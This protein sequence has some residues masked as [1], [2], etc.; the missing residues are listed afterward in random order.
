MPKAAYTG[1][2]GVARK[3]KK[4]YVSPAGVARKVKKGY[5]GV[6]GVARQFFAS[7]TPIGE[8][9]VGT[10]VYMNVNG[11]RTEFFVVHQGLPSSAYD[12]SCND[13]WLLMKDV[14]IRQKNQASTNTNAYEKSTAHTY[15]NDT[16]YNLLD[17]GIKNIVKQVKIPY[18]QGDRANTLLT[19]S[20]GLSTKIFLLSAP[21]VNYVHSDITSGEGVALSYFS[22]CATSAADSKRIAYM[23]GTANHWW[24]RSP[25][26]SHGGMSYYVNTSGGCACA[27]GSSS[28][29]RGTRPALILPKATL[30][31]SNFDI[32]VQ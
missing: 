24:T 15:L 8:L 27:H 19:G 18:V 7:G 3:N 5:V 17:A 28:T 10:S 22:S 25:C 9:P 12:S 23:N 31:D 13:T 16:F 14:Y 1:V 2:G 32:T 11:V 4:I 30:V 29:T 21:E 26:R 20:N 6:D